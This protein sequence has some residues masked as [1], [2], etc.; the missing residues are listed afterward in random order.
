MSLS[1]PDTV[2]IMYFVR[3]TNPQGLG[4]RTFAY[5]LGHYWVSV[6]TMILGGLKGLRPPGT[7]G[8]SCLRVVGPVM[9]LR[10]LLA[11]YLGNF[12]LTSQNDCVLWTPEYILW[13]L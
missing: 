1:F 12:T 13:F 3:A 5:L 7:G 4:I 8:I 11:E 6:Y 10:A 9:G 2:H